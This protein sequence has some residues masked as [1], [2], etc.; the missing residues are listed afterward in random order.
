MRLGPFSLDRTRLFDHLTGE[1]F[2]KTVDS[3][4]N[5]GWDRLRERMVDDAA[6]RFFAELGPLVQVIS[7]G[8]RRIKRIDKD[9]R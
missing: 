2:G 3:S 7:L 9:P 4:N 5:T 6:K 8:L 1:D